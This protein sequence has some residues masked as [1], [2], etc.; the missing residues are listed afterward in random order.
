M[1]QFIVIG[2][3]RFGSSVAKTLYEAGYDVLA[4][5]K[6]EDAIQ[7]ISDFVTH[8]VQVDATDET[9]IKSLGIRNFDVAIVA[10]GSDIQSSILVTLMAKELGVKFVVAKALNELQAKVLYKIGADRVVFPERDMGIRVA[11]NLM[12]ANILDNIE[13][14]SNYSI[15]E[16]AAMKEWE[17]KN[18]KELNLRKKYGI[19]VLIIKRGEVLNS[20]PNPSDIIQKGDVLV[21]IGYKEELQKLDLIV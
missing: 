17:G 20:A 12:S 6:N 3:G 10:I 21:V 19:H 11:H 14:A 8:A 16:I 5:D 7:E 1:R 9:S 2:C 13:L 4:I 15:L 18:L